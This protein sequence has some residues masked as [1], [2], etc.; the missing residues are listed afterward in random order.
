MKA[1]QVNQFGAPDV[2]TLADVPT[3]EPKE[4][5][6][7]IKLAYA[8]LNHVD[9]WVRKGSPAYPVKLPHILGCDGAGIVEAM[10]P[11]AEG[12]SIGDRVVIFPGISD[13]TC[14]ACKRGQDNQ[15]DN[16]EF[17]GTKRHGTYAEFVT[18]PDLNVAAIPDSLSFGQAASYP[19]AYLTAWHMLLGRAKLVAGESV[20]IIGA[21]SGVGVAAIQIAKLKGAHVL[22][23]T[24]SRHK[25][26]KLKSLGA[27]DVFLEEKDTDFSR[28][29]LKSTDMRGADVVFEHVGPA[30]F[31]KSVKSLRRYGRL[32]TCGATTG[33]TVTL[34]LRY[35][36]SRDLT[37]LGAKMGT[38]REFQDLSAAVFNGSIV[39]LVD[40]IFSLADVSNAHDYMEGK[41]QLGKILLKVT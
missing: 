24:S 20:L 5:E 3:P 28:W 40:K 37:I 35:I 26:S 31:E 10:G 8:G 18:V 25:V 17:I 11:Q 39:P 15:C 4:N 32:V 9:I 16:F 22:A 41:Q 1:I 29:A 38:Q 36:F 13:G 2:L 34:D 14:A 19:L 33:P 12:V 23:V 30:T 21:G 7:L 6:I 27:D